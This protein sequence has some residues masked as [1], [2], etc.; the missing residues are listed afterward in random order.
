MKFILFIGF[1]IL[2]FY[3]IF[4]SPDWSNSDNNAKQNIG[5]TI[6]AILIGGS[7]LLTI[8]GT[9]KECSNTFKHNSADHYYDSPRK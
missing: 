7:I 9:I 1:F 8:I 5:C 3:L 2:V 6:M 4:K